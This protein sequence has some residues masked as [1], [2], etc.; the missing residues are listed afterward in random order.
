MLNLL[1]KQ[2]LPCAS[3]PQTESTGEQ[4]GWVEI[5]TS[6]VVI[7]NRDLT[8]KERKINRSARLTDEVHHRP[9]ARKRWVTP[10]STVE[11]VVSCPGVGFVSPRNLWDLCNLRLNYSVVVDRDLTVF[12][13]SRDRPRFYRLRL[14]RG[15]RRR[16]VSG[17]WAF[18]G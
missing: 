3:R 14:W 18:R 8:S 13:T 15:S 5:V 9:R 4:D 16:P 12:F 17:S 2:N 10:K 1:F 7:H 6:M 11:S